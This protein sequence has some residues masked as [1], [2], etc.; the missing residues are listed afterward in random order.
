MENFL[1]LRDGQ[2]FRAHGF[3]FKKEDR[4]RVAGWASARLEP[5]VPRVRVTKYR[6]VECSA[7]VVW[8][9]R[10]VPEQVGRPHGRSTTPRLHGEEHPEGTKRAITACSTGGTGRFS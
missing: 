5:G 1:F 9:P 3:S 2:A 10:G 8:P 7:G 4:L 6:L